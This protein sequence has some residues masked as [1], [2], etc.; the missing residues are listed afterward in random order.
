MH[1]NTEPD[2][3]GFPSPVRE[4]EKK[5]EIFAEKT[6]DKV[7]ETIT[8]KDNDIDGIKSFIGSKKKV[9]DQMADVDLIEHSDEPEST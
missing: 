7:D 1:R 6:N 2:L 5:G 4:Y 9:A 3:T 8:S